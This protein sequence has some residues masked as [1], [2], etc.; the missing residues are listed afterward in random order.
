MRENAK[1]AP[2]PCFSA[3]EFLFPLQT[4]GKQTKQEDFCQH[5]SSKAVKLGID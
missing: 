1:G 2:L 4:L 5:F 3:F